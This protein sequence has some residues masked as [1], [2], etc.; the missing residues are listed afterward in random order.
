MDEDG[1]MSQ[2]LVYYKE[3]QDVTTHDVL[4]D[5]RHI[6]VIELRCQSSTCL[7]VIGV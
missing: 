1:S 6:S 4:Q 2:E 5:D 3:L 7:T